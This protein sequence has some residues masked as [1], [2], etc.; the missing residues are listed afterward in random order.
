MLNVT[1]LGGSRFKACGSLEYGKRTAEAHYYGRLLE[2]LTEMEAVPGVHDEVVI[3]PA[4]TLIR[5]LDAIVRPAY[6]R[7]KS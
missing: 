5:T 6:H 2:C 1:D 4:G 3:Q 7:E